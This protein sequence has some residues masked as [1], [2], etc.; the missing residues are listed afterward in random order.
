M[1]AIPK[2]S[3]VSLNITLTDWPCAIVCITGIV[4]I[5]GGGIYL[6]SRLIKNGYQLQNSKGIS[7]TKSDDKEV[8][9]PELPGKRIATNTIWSG[10]DPK[11]TM[12]TSAPDF[13]IHH[14]FREL[15]KGNRSLLLMT[16]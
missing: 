8:Q 4:V 12:D 6:C 9:K 3:A 11:N 5:G 15:S 7:L 2:L 16:A 10:S 1:K 13:C 14:S